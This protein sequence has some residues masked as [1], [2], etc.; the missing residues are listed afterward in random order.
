M[1]DKVLMPVP[2][3][4]ATKG[5]PDGVSDAP[6]DK[7]S[8]NIHGRSAGGESGGGAY[9]NPQTGKTEKN[10]GFFKHGGQT[11]IGYQGGGQ[12]GEEGTSAQNATAG[13]GGSSRGNGDGP[14]LS[15][16]TAEHAVRTII[17]DGG[18]NIAVVEMSGVAEAEAIGKVGT[19]ANYEAEQEQPGSG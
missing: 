5:A 8:G 6:G 19:D 7:G 10:E 16:P 15:V 2:G 1:T 13:S 11:E 3:D 18:S 9:P 17:G 4:P 14:W 12:A